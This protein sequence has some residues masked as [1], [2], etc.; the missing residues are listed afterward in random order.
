MSEKARNIMNY[1]VS[2]SEEEVIEDD[3]LSTLDF[4]ET[5]LILG[6]IEEKKMR[7]FLL[8]TTI[9]YL[10]SGQYTGTYPANINKKLYYDIIVHRCVSI[11][12]DQKSDMEIIQKIVKTK[13]NKVQIISLL[14]L[15]IE[16]YYEKCTKNIQTFLSKK[17]QQLIDTPTKSGTY[18]ELIDKLKEWKEYQTLTDTNIKNIEE[19]IQLKTMYNLHQKILE[20]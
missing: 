5:L 11:I 14:Q 7:S 2:L 17:Q 10:K 18:D 20:L 1:I 15:V 4:A 3:T 19:S 13:L 12:N 16:E 6:I 8:S 9:E